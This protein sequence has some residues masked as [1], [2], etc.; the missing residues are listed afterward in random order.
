MQEN[1]MKMGKD[2]SA[3][4]RSVATIKV[5]AHSLG[6]QWTR[7]QCT[8]TL[9][10]RAL[11][12]SLSQKQEVLLANFVNA[13]TILF[14]LLNKSIWEVKIEA[15]WQEAVLNFTWLVCRQIPLGPRWDTAWLFSHSVALHCVALPT[16]TV[17]AYVAVDQ[18]QN[19]EDA[20]KITKNDFLIGAYTV[21]APTSNQGLIAPR[22]QTNSPRTD[23]VAFIGSIP[24]FCNTYLLSNMPIH[25]SIP[26]LL[27]GL[28]SDNSMFALGFPSSFLEEWRRAHIYLLGFAAQFD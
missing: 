16:H 10:F 18:W 19:R 14:L 4:I 13:H 11:S 17:K 7:S 20:L 2:W 15:G 9:L 24:N 1:D 28:K 3:F 6:D 25:V 26:K 12:S 21:K 5:L 27:T 22:W 8:P 23:Q